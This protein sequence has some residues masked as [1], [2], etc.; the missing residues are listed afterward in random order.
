MTHV[1]Q[2]TAPCNPVLLAAVVL[3]ALP[4]LSACSNDGLFVSSSSMNET[5][6]REGLNSLILVPVRREYLE[7]QNFNRITDFKVLAMYSG[8]TI[9]IGSAHTQVRVSNG[10]VNEILP[11]TEYQFLAP[12]EWRITV[13]YGGKSGDYAVWVFSEDGQSGP[14]LPGNGDTTINIIIRE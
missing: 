13:S 1:K 9:E 11:S 10:T 2:Y 12:G 3:L 4:S 7:G 5:N 8:G 6:S 14:G